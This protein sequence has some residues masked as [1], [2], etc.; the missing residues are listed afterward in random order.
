MAT[1]KITI[2]ALPDLKAHPR[3]AAALKRRAELAAGLEDRA[4][5]LRKVNKSIKT[6]TAPTGVGFDE[7]GIGAM[8]DDAAAALLEGIED[9]VSAIGGKDELLAAKRTIEWEIEVA[10]RA[11]EI[12][13]RKEVGPACQEA[14]ERVGREVFDAVWKPLIRE[15]YQATEAVAVATAKLVETAQKLDDAGYWRQPVAYPY[16]LPSNPFGHVAE[17]SGFL[18]QVARELIEGGFATKGDPLFANLAK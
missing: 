8:I 11:I 7:N 10:K 9:A 14:F 17:K 1:A 15:A 2:D 3:Y 13:D 5:E 12:F 18:A 4:A 16:S 6:M